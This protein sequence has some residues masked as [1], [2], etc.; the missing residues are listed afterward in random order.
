MD[1]EDGDDYEDTTTTMTT[2]KVQGETTSERHKIHKSLLLYDDTERAKETRLRTRT[3]MKM[4]RRTKQG[5]PF[6]FLLRN[7]ITMAKN[8]DYGN[9][10][11][12]NFVDA[13][14]STHKFTI[15]A[16]DN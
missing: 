11:N 9:F 10:S 12:W 1:D 14:R 16:H 15:L 5:S 4:K 13:Q 3:R 7:K 8:R 2:V 6:S